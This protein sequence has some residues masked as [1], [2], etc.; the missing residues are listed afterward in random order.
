MNT[1]H[2]ACLTISWIIL[3]SRQQLERTKFT[4]GADHYAFKWI[5]NL[6]DDTGK[7]ERWRIHLMDYKLNI[8]HKV[9]IKPRL[10][11]NFCEYTLNVPMIPES[12]KNYHSWPLSHAH[13]NGS[14]K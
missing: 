10:L 3:C 8:V 13:R 7:L 2:R 1:I 6:V 14:E 12:T 4:V 11:D 5:F 9:H